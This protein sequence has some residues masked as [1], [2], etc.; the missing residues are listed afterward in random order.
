MDRNMIGLLIGGLL[1]AIIYALSGT[2]QKV[3][4]KAGVGVGPYLT[5]L[6]LG[7]S[8]VGVIAC[9]VLPR[10][11]ASWLGLGSS[12]A[13]GVIWGLGTGAVLWALSAT[14][15]PI[16]KL[17]PLYNMNTL[18]AVLLGLWFFAEAKELQLL[19]LLGGAAL[20]ALGSVLVSRA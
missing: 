12:G 8:L 18:F 6:G 14:G 2:L 13:V 16:A 15:V 3:P 19:P 20:I 1:P 7:V 17:V 9:F 5:L 10:G 4:A 11:T